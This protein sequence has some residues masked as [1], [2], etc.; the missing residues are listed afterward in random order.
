MHQML[1]SFMFIA[2]TLSAALAHPNLQNSLSVA[3]ETS[4]VRVDV[5]VSVK[6]LSV[7]HGIEGLPIN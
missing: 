4:R 5:N 1:L 6:E 2:L 7:A 3:F